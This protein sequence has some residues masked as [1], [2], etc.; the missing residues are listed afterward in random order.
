MFFF[1]TRVKGRWTLVV[2]VGLALL[3]G[4]FGVILPPLCASLVALRACLNLTAKAWADQISLALAI[5]AVRL[6]HCLFVATG[7]HGI[8]ANIIAVHVVLRRPVISALRDQP[9][10]VLI[11]VAKT[12]WGLTIC[13]LFLSHVPALMALDKPGTDVRN[14]P[15]TALL[16]FAVQ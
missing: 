11:R 9:E 4:R 12:R 6:R 15:V 10:G 7:R 13:V 3:S 16:A 5:C 8:C 14:V 2:P 1:Q